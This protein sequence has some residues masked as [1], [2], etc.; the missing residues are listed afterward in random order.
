MAEEE[1]LE[2]VVAFDAEPGGDSDEREALPEGKPLIEVLAEPGE[3]LSEEQERAIRDSLGFSRTETRTKAERDAAAAKM[4]A[5]SEQDS[6]QGPLPP[7]IAAAWA[8]KVDGM[9]QPAE[10]TARFLIG[11]WGLDKFRGSALHKQA[12]AEVRRAKD[13]EAVRKAFLDAKAQKR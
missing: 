6:F 5:W 2:F 12:L 3:E 9:G 4:A 1:E 11:A 7:D 10:N 13:K 8:G